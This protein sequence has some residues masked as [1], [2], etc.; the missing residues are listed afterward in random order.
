LAVSRKPAR[1]ASVIA[2]IKLCGLE[3][4]FDRDSPIRIWVVFAEFLMFVGQVAWCGFGG[5]GPGDAARF[6]VARYGSPL[7]AAKGGR[8][9]LEGG[10][11]RMVVAALP[12]SCGLIHTDT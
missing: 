12:H 8:G 7:A 6:L 11:R 2:K 3:G 4:T 9:R 10:A 1:S 5:A